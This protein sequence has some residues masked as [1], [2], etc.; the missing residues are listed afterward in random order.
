MGRTLLQQ[1]LPLTFGL[2]AA[3]WLSGIVAARAELTEVRDRVLAVQLGGAVGTLAAL[4][5]RGLDV[6][7]DVATQL[8]LA[9]PE[10]PWHT[11]RMRAAR[12]AC[13]LGTTL[14]VMGKVARDVVLLAQTEVAEATEASGQGR[15]GSSTMPHKRNPVG[16]ITVL[17]CAQRGPGLVATMLGAMVQEHERAAG[18]WQAEWATLSELMQLTAAAA[19]S[20][21]EV[22]DG[23]EV[24]V[25]RMRSNLD[26]LG[27]L[28]MTES[29]ATAL[30]EQLGRSAAQEL[31][32]EAATRSEAERRPL[33]D[34]LLE[35][36]EI[37]DG[38]GGEALE[39]SL[40]PERYLGAAHEL[41]ER[42][43]A[44]HRR[45]VASAS[46]ED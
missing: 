14:G 15:G 10:L 2:K 5:D 33:R 17:A 23:I 25:V 8:E 38:L 16:S 28:V 24:D 36:V 27:G 1:A 22:L 19:A 31:V 12:L 9:E 30:G 37:A 18:G 40:D 20:L 6:V 43:L 46:A 32:E 21:A 39:R 42:A 13:T 7:A 26:A 34:V 4:R 11:N 35:R 3:S 41:I 29:V 44:A 45:L